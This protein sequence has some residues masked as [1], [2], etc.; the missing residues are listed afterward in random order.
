MADVSQFELFHGIVLTKLV[1]N[2]APVTLRLIETNTNDAWAAYR[3]NAA[4]IVYT[5][6]RTTG[7]ELL[8]EDGGCSFQFV[9][10]P[11]ELAALR[12]L[13]QDSAVYVVLVCGNRDLSKTDQMHV[14]MIEPAELEQLIDVSS[15][16]QQN[17]LVK[18]LPRR[19][20]RVTGSNSDKELLIAHRRLDDWQVPGS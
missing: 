8:R 10:L 17:I 6:V 3:I 11:G 14:C 18:H 2:D 1:R 7:Y 15:A 5:K 19:K 20:F 4:V 13:A 9:F 16:D 12:R